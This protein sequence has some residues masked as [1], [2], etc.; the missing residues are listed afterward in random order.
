[1][2]RH[3]GPKPSNRKHNWDLPDPALRDR[4]WKVIGTTRKLCG[5]SYARWQDLMDRN[6][7]PG[8]VAFAA[9]Q[10]G[11]SLRADLVGALG[12]DLRAC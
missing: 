7:V 11:L 5:G 12:R 9:S 1:M 2:I 3:A 10:E 4:L 6:D 8:L